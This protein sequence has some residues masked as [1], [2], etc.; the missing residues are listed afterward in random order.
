MIT[1]RD[2]GDGKYLQY[3]LYSWKRTNSPKYQVFVTSFF[4]HFCGTL[5]SD[6]PNFTK[7]LRIW[8]IKCHHQHPSLL[9]TKMKGSLDLCYLSKM[10]LFTHTIQIHFGGLCHHRRVNCFICVFLTSRLIWRAV[11]GLALRR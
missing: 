7:L 4:F 5:P 10:K 8:T 9:I 11:L 1:E 6:P 2:V 3:K